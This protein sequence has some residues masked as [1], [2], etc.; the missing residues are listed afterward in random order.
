MDYI[1][2]FEKIE[3]KKTQFEEYQKDFNSKRG[4]MAGSSF[5][6]CTDPKIRELYQAITS[7]MEQM[8]SINSKMGNVWASF[9][10]NMKEKE[11]SLTNFN[12]ANV[13]A[14]IPFEG[15]IEPIVDE[16][17]IPVL[18]GEKKSLQDLGK[19]I[20]PPK[21]RNQQKPSSTGAPNY[22]PAAGNPYVGGYSNCTWG[23][24]NLMKENTGI[25]LPNLGNAYS[26]LTN[27]QAAG[28]STGWAP[29]PGSVAVYS[30]HVAYVA[31]VSA[32]GTQVLIKEGGYKGGYNERWV[33]ATGTGTQGLQGYIYG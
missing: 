5:A 1:I 32:D 3:N 12:V 19:I 16:K 8:D 31:A 10:T 27:A 18:T 11:N 23:A 28:M 15:E 4:Q 26:W 14:P 2:E 30:N 20:I 9:L 7:E 25:S 24:W 22:A 17:I 21:T 13:E 6:Q 29:A 33:S